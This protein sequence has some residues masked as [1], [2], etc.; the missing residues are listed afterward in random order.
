MSDRTDASRSAFVLLFVLGGGW[1]FELSGN[2][3]LVDSHT[4]LFGDE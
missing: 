4:G 2:E 1:P 3:D